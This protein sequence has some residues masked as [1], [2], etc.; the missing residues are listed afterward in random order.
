MATP[1]ISERFRSADADLTIQSSDA[2]LFK[3]HRKNL[4]VHSVVFAGAESAT[5]PENDDEIVRLPETSEVLDL[6]FQ[7]MYPQPQPDLTALEFQTFAD[8]AEA[9]E[10][11]MVFSALTLC[12]MK[13]KDSVPKH[14]LEVLNYAVKHGHAFADEAA[15]QSMSRGVGDAMKILD[16]GIFTTWVSLYPYPRHSQ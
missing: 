1:R 5:L 14:A 3:V 2:V 9:A 7:F 12:H 11:Y 6:L 8:L 16:P 13:M 15:R 4:E 10:K